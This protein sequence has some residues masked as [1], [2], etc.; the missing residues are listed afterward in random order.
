MTAQ[1][2]KLR[3]ITIVRWLRACPPHLRADVASAIADRQIDWGTLAAFDA[4]GAGADASRWPLPENPSPAAL[5]L[6]NGL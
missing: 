6:L 3:P 2:L 5:A 4:P 1:P